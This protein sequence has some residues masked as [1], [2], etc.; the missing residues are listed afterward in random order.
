MHTHAPNSRKEE[1]RA[2]WS[3]QEGGSQE[4]K[5]HTKAHRSKR[6]QHSEKKS[7]VAALMIIEYEVEKV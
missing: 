2:V 1:V 6:V 7:S 3:S 4:Q 5:E